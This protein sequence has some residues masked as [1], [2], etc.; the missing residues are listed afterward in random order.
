V[1]F[2]LLAAS[3]LACKKDEVITYDQVNATDDQVEVQVGVPE[4]L[5]PVTTDLHSSTGEVVIGTAEVRPGGGPIGTEHEILV[6]V[7]DDYQDLVDR[8]SVRT[9]SA[10]RGE[11]EYDLDQ[12]SADEGYYKTTLVT[13]GSEGEVRTD[14]LTF[15]LWDAQTSDTGSS[16]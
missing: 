10:S 4:E 2:L 6:I 8:V 16:N 5:D 9:E 15:R 14:M 1:T 7:T 13:R 3:L 11:D 12:D